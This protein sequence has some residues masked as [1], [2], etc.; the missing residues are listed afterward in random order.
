MGGRSKQVVFV[1]FAFGFLKEFCP[2]LQNREMFSKAGRAK[3]R[4]NPCEIES[5][6][7]IRHKSVMLSD[8]QL[9]L[10]HFCSNGVYFKI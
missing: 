3:I 2:R 9:D 1:L 8:L 7:K 4:T 10:F 6:A 5:C